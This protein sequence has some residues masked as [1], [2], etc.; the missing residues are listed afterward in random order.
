MN[1]LSEVIEINELYMHYHPLLTDKQRL[2]MTYYFQD[3][4]SLGEIAS[5][6]HISRNAVHD[7][8]KRTVQKLYDFEDKLRL[9]SLSKQRK[10]LLDELTKTHDIDVR[11]KLINELKK[12]V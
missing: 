2:I 5:L 9:L 1:T 10:K 3:D 4:Y 11:N 12:V 7:Q 8:I 6:E